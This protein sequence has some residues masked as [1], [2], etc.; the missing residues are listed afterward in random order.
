MNAANEVAVAKFLAGE[1]SFPAIW[2]H[3]ASAMEAHTVVES[4]SLEELVAADEWARS[5]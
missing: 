4:P 5:V 2:E 3:V 1:S